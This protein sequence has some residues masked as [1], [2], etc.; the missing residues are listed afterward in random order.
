VTTSF[1]ETNIDID[2]SKASAWN[3]GMRERTEWLRKNAPVYWSEK[4]EV[5]VLTR[6]ADVVHASK[7]NDIL[8]SAWPY[9]LKDRLDRRR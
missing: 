4:T 7:N 6:F 5:Y 3:A 2:F 8:C 9:Q 1:D